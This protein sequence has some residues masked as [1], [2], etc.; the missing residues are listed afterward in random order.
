MNALERATAKLVEIVRRIE[1]ANT[2][3]DK[4]IKM[5]VTQD[6]LLKR[7]A[8]EQLRLVKRNE[9]L[10]KGIVEAR[11]PKPEPKPDT[12]I[13][14]FLKRDAKI[15]AEIKAEVDDRKKRKARGRV[16]TML[17]KKAGET[18]RMPLAGREAERYLKTL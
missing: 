16:A 2:N 5:L 8:R 4:A 3:R 1:V 6:A 7:L 15:A 13:P 14:D 18:T 10:A 9:K 11:E 12:G 17:A